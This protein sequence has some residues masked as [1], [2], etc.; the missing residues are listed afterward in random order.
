VAPSGGTNGSGVVYS[1]NTDGSYFNVLHTFTAVDT[2]SYT[3]FEGASPYAALVLSGNTLYGAAEIGGQGGGTIF[4][5][6]IQPTIAN[7][8]LAGT[9]L[10]IDGFNG[11]A[12]EN[13]V[14]LFSPDLASPVNWTPI[15][16]NLLPAGNFTIIVTNA[17]ASSA[18][19]G[20][21]VLQTH[22]E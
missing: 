3:N 20:F 4:S 19:N 14:T 5:L 1:I 11:V 12:G 8:Q 22:A 13:C 7:L 17:V 2:N 18:S 16:T 10:V 15:A 9:N 21:Y 6:V